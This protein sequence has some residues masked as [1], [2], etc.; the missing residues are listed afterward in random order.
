[1]PKDDELPRSAVWHPCCEGVAAACAED[2]VV[3]FRWHA[4]EERV[5]E[6][7]RLNTPGMSDPS[8]VLWSTD[9]RYLC[10]LAED[11]RRMTLPVIEGLAVPAEPIWQIPRQVEGPARESPGEPAD[12]ECDAEV[13]DF[14]SWMVERRASAVFLVRIVERVS[15]A[16]RSCR[17]ASDEITVG[18]LPDNELVLPGLTVS[19]RH[20]RFIHRAG[21]VVVVD[22]GSTNGTW[23]NGRRLQGAEV[24][25]AED[26]L[27]IGD[28]VVTAELGDG[29]AEAGDGPE[30]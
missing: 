15:G 13:L 29:L 18:R 28:F 25:D 11:G 21:R 5:Q 30:L 12:A 6:L 16:L 26:L 22:L 24:L 7:R 19:R 27:V 3:L 9:G 23:L 17:F 10:C 14:P 20:A 1:V 4:P 2:G 8:R